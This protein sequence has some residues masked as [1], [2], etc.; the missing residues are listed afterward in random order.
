M[1]GMRELCLELCNAD[2]E[3]RVVAI[4]KKAGFWDD[5]SAWDYYG[6]YENN[7]QTIGNQQSSPEA[8]LVEK[9]V[10]SIDAVLMRECLRASI[11]PE[12]PDAPGSLREA[13]EL[14]FGVKGGV[15]TSLS[16]SRRSEL[17]QNIMVVATGGKQNPSY[18]IVD[19]GEGQSPTMISKT[20]LS[21]TASN[22]LRIPFV[23][24]KFNMG[25]TGALQ[26]C[27]GLHNVQLIVSRRDP[28][29]H[30]SA[31]DD[32]DSR[33][34]GFTVVRRENPTS[35]K[36]SSTFK[37]LAPEG[38]IPAFPAES[39]P[40]LPGDYPRAYEQ[41][42]E[43]GT[44]IKLYEY[45]LVGYKAPIVF[46]L[47]YRLAELLPNTAL[48][49]LLCERRDG[50]SGHTF[51]TV[52][53]GLSV[54]LEEDKAQNIE[55]GFPSSGTSK[56]RGQEMRYQIYAFKADKKRQYA[57]DGIV[58][59]INGQSHG[60]VSK[61][62]FTRKTVG[63]GYL[64]DSILVTV[65]CSNFD[66]RTREDLFMN[67]RDRLRGGETKD[68]IEHELESIVGHHQGLRELKE[69]R[70]REEIEGKIG[71]AKPL[72]DILEK[73]IKNSPALQ[74]LFIEGAKITNPFKLNGTGTGL[75]FKGRKFPRYFRL[76]KD[77]PKGKPKNC[78]TNQRFRVQ[79]E[80][81]ADNDY[82]TRDMFP[83]TFSL[84][85]MR[86]GW[87]PDFTLNL[88][89]G[90]ATLTTKLP[91]GLNVG[92]EF[93]ISTSVTD[94]TQ[95][96]PFQNS[97]FVAVS[98]AL[99]PKNGGEGHGREPPGPEGD[100][101]HR[102][103]RLALPTIVEVRRAEWPHHSFDK[104]SALKVVD[105]G[106]EGY[107]FFIN[108]D[109]AYLQ[110]ELKS[111]VAAEPN[112]LEAQYKYGLVLLGLSLIRALEEEDATGKIPNGVELYQIIERVSK[113]I[114]PV[115]LPMIATLGQIE[116]D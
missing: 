68:D 32:A 113:A 41:P 74:K 49:I 34:W 88:W 6:G 5:P 22:K 25:G 103:S 97:F 52:L 54:R 19:K 47:Y 27:G 30:L 76:R 11:D 4:L 56:V 99:G 12:G 62:F 85:P 87:V 26:F 116:V 106:E 70:R 21:L 57:D 69:R 73:A 8:A 112:I 107:D 58:F 86:E 42:L 89:N 81:D 90:I 46:D 44:F 96:N 101:R 65:D 77:F 10:N 53:S 48:P 115:L 114:A 66:G 38:K 39:L 98:S 23:Q 93:E 104:E 75:V 17:A 2:V 84:S 78:P 82:F 13:M 7:F 28:Q 72:V 9:V 55:P 63:L 111:R 59:S 105:S 110:T 94:D 3:S 95:V 18:T 67:S 83:G 16:T 15:L 33:L 50:Y 37:Y 92:D 100:D 102:P 64:A 109:N 108:M 61:S 14:F 45:Q 71:D 43:W 1:V 80:T 91:K 20:F 36:R 24:G 60:F 31:D 35:G 51:H 29:I 40:L 79:F